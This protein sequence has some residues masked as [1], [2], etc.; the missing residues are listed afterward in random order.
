MRRRITR[1]LFT[2]AAAGVTITTL[3]FAAASPAG[4]AAASH[5]K[6]K[7]FT[8]TGTLVGTNANCTLANIALPSDNCGKAGYM[9]TGRTF[10]FAQALITV[11]NHLGSIV[12][13]ADPTAYVALDNSGTN[14]W[15]YTRVGIAPC[16]AAAVGIF[17]VPGPGGAIT[18]PT[19]VAG[20]TSNWV[21]FVATADAGAPPTVTTHPIPNAAMGDGILVNAYLASTGNSVSTT[22]T[23]PDGTTYNNTFPITGPTYTNAQ[24]V[25]D[26]TTA[27]ENGA[28]A[29]EPAVPVNK[30]R[31]LQFFQ[32]RFTTSSGAQGTFNGPWTLN[33]W[34]AT[35]NGTLPPTGTLIGQPS[36]LWNDGNGFGGKGDDAFGVWRF[37]F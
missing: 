14:T 16:P 27:I 25:A 8:P 36:Y 30:V 1:T 19:V 37:P 6:V 22:I 34:E 13:P 2:A 21:V 5:H 28:A 20:N 18:C 32:G 7:P 9:A 23:M 12:S 24:A 4:A 17:I 33:A 11:P 26:W 31:D 10:R 15:Q 3:G 35:S 29:P